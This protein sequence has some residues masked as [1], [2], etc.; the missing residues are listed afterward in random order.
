MKSRQLTIFGCNLH[1]GLLVAGAGPRA[2]SFAPRG[3]AK[4]SAHGHGLDRVQALAQLEER[5]LPALLAR[6]PRSCR[7]S[8]LKAETPYPMLR[9]LPCTTV[10]EKVHSVLLSGPIPRKPKPDAT[11]VRTQTDWPTFF[12]RLP[13]LGITMKA[14]ARQGYARRSDNCSSLESVF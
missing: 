2:L 3:I 5:E 10:G 4:S 1:G 7:N 9:E 14:R 13:N 12:S 11:R 6:E 8:A